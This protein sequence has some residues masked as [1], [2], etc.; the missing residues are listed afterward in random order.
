M[1]L[2]QRQSDALIYTLL[3]VIEP[4][5]VSEGSLFI[6]QED[7]RFPNRVSKV[8]TPD[9]R[10]VITA[11]VKVLLCRDFIFGEDLRSPS[12]LFLAEALAIIGVAGFKV[13]W[14][15]L[16]QSLPHI[17]AHGLRLRDEAVARD[18]FPCMLD[19]EFNAQ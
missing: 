12:S 11:D 13:Y 5:V 8:M 19:V 10:L 17:L 9:S 2:K 18:L 3:G 15:L 16:N 1:T 4:D 14:G 6:R 7:I